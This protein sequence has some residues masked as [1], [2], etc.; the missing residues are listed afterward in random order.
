M[1]EC[2]IEFRPIKKIVVHEIEMLKLSEFKARHLGS[3]YA[4]NWCDGVLFIMG[5]FPTQ[6]ELVRKD[7]VNGVLHWAFVDVAK[8]PARPKTLKKDDS[9]TKVE[10]SDMSKTW[11]IKQFCSWVKKQPFWNEA[12]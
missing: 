4:P 8:H 3:S 9:D 5:Y 2:E 7:E 6:N 1:P 10:V 12:K 11:Y